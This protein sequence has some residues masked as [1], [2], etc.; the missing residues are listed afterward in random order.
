MYHNITGTA[1]HKQSR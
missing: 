1:R